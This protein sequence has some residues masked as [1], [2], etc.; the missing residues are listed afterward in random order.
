MNALTENGELSKSE[1]LQIVGSNCFNNKEKH[2]GEVLKRLVDKKLIK[3]VKQGV[4]ALDKSN[5]IDPKQTSLFG[6]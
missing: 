6:E 2:F 3:R 4:Y 5:Y 1:L